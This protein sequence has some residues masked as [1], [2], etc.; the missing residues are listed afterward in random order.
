MAPLSF[1]QT[2]VSVKL[3]MAVHVSLTDRMPDRGALCQAVN[4]I[5]TGEAEPVGVGTVFV[6]AVL[7]GPGT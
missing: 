4:V 6:L 7:D 3:L 5:I 1:E 2:I